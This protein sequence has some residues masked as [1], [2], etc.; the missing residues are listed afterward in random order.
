MGALW[1]QDA[2]A[3]G[4]RASPVSIR[5]GGGSADG[6]RRLPRGSP[7]P[8]GRLRRPPSRDPWSGEKGL[9]AVEKGRFI[10]VRRFF[11]FAISRLSRLISGRS[12]F[13]SEFEGIVDDSRRGFCRVPH[14]IFLEVLAHGEED[15]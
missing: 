10:R 14:W 6:F 7:H 12:A 3:S 4:C 8:A 9:R 11:W 15:R 13:V 5:P 1:R 2:S